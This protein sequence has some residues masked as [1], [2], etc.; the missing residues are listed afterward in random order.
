MTWRFPTCYIPR[1]ERNSLS[2]RDLQG[3]DKN[4]NEH[5]YPQSLVYFLKPPNPK[6]RGQ[7]MTPEVR[8]GNHL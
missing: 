3:Y 7:A 2:D 6:V 8:H 5:A 4:L 1:A